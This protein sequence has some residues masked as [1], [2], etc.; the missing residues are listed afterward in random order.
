MKRNFCDGENLQI[1]KMNETYNGSF[2][3]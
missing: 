1:L 2:I 3:V